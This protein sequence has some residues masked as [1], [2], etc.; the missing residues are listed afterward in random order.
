M[1][2]K[3]VI[4]E[5][6]YTYFVITVY[7][8]IDDVEYVRSGKIWKDDIFSSFKVFMEMEI[9]EALNEGVLKLF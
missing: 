4:N 7:E 3:V 8:V 2:Y 1:I 6:Y 5:E 9:K